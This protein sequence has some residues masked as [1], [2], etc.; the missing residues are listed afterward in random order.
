MRKTNRQL[1]KKFVPGEITLSFFLDYSPLHIT[2][3]EAYNLKVVNASK[4]LEG[5]NNQTVF[6]F[7]Y[8]MN[9]ISIKLLERII[10]KK[11]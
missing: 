10:N 6:Y 2:S 9:I 1:E 4:Y 8:K 11:Y 3:L 5:L 7:F